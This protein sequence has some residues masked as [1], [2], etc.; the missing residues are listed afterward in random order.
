M[1]ESNVEASQ[2]DASEGKAQPS[3]VAVAEVAEN[4]GRE[5]L[6]HLEFRTEV[7]ISQKHPAHVTETDSVDPNPPPVEEIKLDQHQPVLV[8]DHH[9]APPEEAILKE[10]AEV[11]RPTDRG[12]LKKG[13]RPALRVNELRTGA[14]FHPVTSE[15]R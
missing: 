5:I 1:A 14:A 15:S 3:P 6:I 9:A 8:V 13:S 12:Q 10:A 11:F 2:Y 4:A 7:G